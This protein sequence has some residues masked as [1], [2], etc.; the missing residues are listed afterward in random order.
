ML[1]YEYE[2]KTRLQKYGIPIPAGELTSSADEL[3]HVASRFGVPVLLKPQLQS[4]SPRLHKVA[5]S[6]DE[7]RNFILPLLADH[8]AV[9]KVLVEPVIESQDEISL[10]IFG[11]YSLGQPVMEAFY[12]KSQGQFTAGTQMDT[13]Y[14]REAINPL[15]GIHRYQIR[16][17]AGSLLLPEEHWEL[18]SWIAHNLYQCYVDNDATLIELNPLMITSSNQLLVQGC[19]MEI[20]D[21]ALFRH[22]DLAINDI[23]RFNH[24]R[25]GLRILKSDSALGCVVNGIGQKLAIT[26]MIADIHQELPPPY[27]IDVGWG[28]KTS[29]VNHALEIF[30]SHPTIRVILISLSG[31]TTGCDTF[32]H[33]IINVYRNAPRHLPLIVHFQGT[34]SLEA[35]EILRNGDVPS[36]FSTSFSQAVQSAIAIVKT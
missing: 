4:T 3:Y 25:T 5:F 20:D 19:I 30:L 35:Q 22:A 15:V 29:Q 36:S 6:P 26:D 27:L 34:K 24:H 33:G 18:F 28:V 10:R 2:A 14:I 11:D 16:N 23:G 13:G 12:T 1:L 8:E 21:N 7:A 17:I 32:S 9:Q 31:G